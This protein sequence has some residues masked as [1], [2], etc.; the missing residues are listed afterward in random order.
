MIVVSDSL[1]FLCGSRASIEKV[2]GEGGQRF[3]VLCDGDCPQYDISRL[4]IEYLGKHPIHREGALQSIVQI[5]AA[6]RFPVVR[7]RGIPHQLWCTSREDET[8]D[9]M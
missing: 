9:K 2:P 1:C 7:V 8:K 6:G 4:A 3:D 5:A